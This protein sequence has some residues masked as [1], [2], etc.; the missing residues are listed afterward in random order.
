MM[1]G[2]CFR[3]RRNPNRR[4]SQLSWNLRRAHRTPKIRIYT[5]FLR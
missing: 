1:R 5:Q 2:H 4:T 3:V